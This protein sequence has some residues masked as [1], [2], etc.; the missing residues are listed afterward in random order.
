MRQLTRWLSVALLLGLVLLLGRTGLLASLDDGLQDWR[1]S[2]T[3]RPVSGDTVFVAVDSKSL[4]EVGTWPWPRSLYGR[5]LDRLMDAGA[6]EVAF[7][8]DFSS[9]S[10]PAEDAAFAAA[11][12]RA[13]GFAVLAAFVQDTGADGL[14][15]SRPLPQF[16]QWA[17]PVLVNVLID[18][19]A[20][21]A[22]WVPKSASD[23]S[24]PM[25]ALAARLGQPTTTLP[26]LVTID[27][28]LDLS[29][30]P[31]FSFTDVLD[32]HVAPELLAGKKVIVGASAIEL[33]DFFH[34]PRYGIIS[35]PLVQALAAETVR[36]GR[37]IR[38]FSGLPGLGL[39]AGLALVIL[40]LGRA[41]VPVAEPSPLAA[42]AAPRRTPQLVATPSRH[43]CRA[44]S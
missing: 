44:R 9:S 29:G 42:A 22:R 1:L 39:V 27:Y 36:T 35:G 5:V 31:R 10:T 20:G 8:I 38:D 6:D 2:M 17:D 43:R 33:R 4:A 19:N 24:G 34:V 21:H 15:V 12:E 16:T 13:G 14:M 41:P 32:G 25:E 11:L 18:G 23:G 40:A 7:D 37:I 3:S 28:S 30:I 26:D